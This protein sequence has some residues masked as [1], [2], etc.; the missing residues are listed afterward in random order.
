MINFRYHIVSLMAVFIA[1][2]VG[3][4]VGVSLSP[5]V[6]EGIISQADQDRRQVT[7]L[8]AEIS[9]RD[10]LDA[11]RD[12]WAQQVSNVVLT[13]ELNGTRVALVSMPGAPRTVTDAIS[14]AVQGAGG[15][16]VAEVRVSDEVF[17]PARAGELADTFDQIKGPSGI[18]ETMSA[19]TKFG[20]ALARSIASA[21]PGPRDP[22]AKRVGTV[23]TGAGLTDIREDTVPT[24]Q[25]VIVVTAPS[26]TPLAPAEVTAGHVE[27]ELALKQQDPAVG[28]VLAGPDSTGVEG[29]DVLAARTTPRADEALSTVDVADLPSGVSTVVWAG[30]EQVL[31]R[32][33]HY[34]ALT[35]ADAALPQLP[36][37]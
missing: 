27:S 36:V 1:L 16:V 25:L 5:S 30:K 35:R 17:D 28:V 9:R 14:T 10:A 15:M 4:A 33:G 26:T 20:R 12:T 34:G 19:P 18:V 23:L 13:G 8:R 6:D 21:S 2:A 31:G 3:I 37:R 11:Y 22:A 29:T 7:D 32:Q 24:A